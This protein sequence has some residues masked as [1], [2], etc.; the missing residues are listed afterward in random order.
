MVMTAEDNPWLDYF[1]DDWG[2]DDEAEAL[3]M[4]GIRERFLSPDESLLLAPVLLERA[5]VASHCLKLHRLNELLQELPDRFF[6]GDLRACARMLGYRDEEAAVLPRRYIYPAPTFGRWDLLQTKNGWQAME[7]NAG[8]AV[9]GV[10]CA[11][12]QARYDALRARA[13]VDDNEAGGTGIDALQAVIDARCAGLAWSHAVVLDDDRQYAHSPLTAQTAARALSRLLNTQVEAMPVSGFQPPS[14]GV[15]LVFEVF[16]PRDMARM[17]ELYHRYQSA[18][19]LNNIIS[20]NPPAT[21]ILMSKA[22]LAMLYEQSLAGRFDEGDT[23]IIQELLP[24][25]YCLNKA[26]SLEGFIEGKNQW[27]LKSAIGYGGKDV[28][29]GW[30]AVAQEWRALLEKAACG[31]DLYVIQKRIQGL[32][33]NLLAMTPQGDYIER[34]GAP[35]LGI[36]L[37][38]GAFA[39]GL[40]RASVNASAVVN[41]HNK[42]AVGV[43]RI[44][45]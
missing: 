42:A 11:A 38:K 4:A 2:A 5:A 25:T 7:F 30:E 23:R 26:S 14:E 13:G 10:D 15:A 39:G 24:E 9:S 6:D 29:C 28:Y 41:A 31:D 36:F 34:R 8:G 43:M 27:V 21:D 37:N 17:P 32:E 44:R 1:L 45:G 35:V 18:L 16:T 33:E 40:A 12:M 22:T 20:I 19:D 3:R